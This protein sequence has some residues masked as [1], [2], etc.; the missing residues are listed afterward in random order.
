[1]CCVLHAADGVTTA[2]DMLGTDAAEATLQKPSS[3]IAGESA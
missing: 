2:G 3:A 1:M